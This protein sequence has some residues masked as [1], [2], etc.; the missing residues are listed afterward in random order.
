VSLSG[1]APY[2]RF[3][4]LGP[5]AAWTAT[6]CSKYF[7]GGPSEDAVAMLEYVNGPLTFLSETGALSL[8]APHLKLCAFLTRCNA[9]DAAFCNRDLYL[10]VT[11]K[12]ELAGEGHS[13]A[14]DGL[15]D[16]VYEHRLPYRLGD[17]A[18]RSAVVDLYDMIG[19]LADAEA[20][21]QS[22][23]TPGLIPMYPRYPL[24]LRGLPVRQTITR[25]A[26][27][28]VSSG[29]PG[30]TEATQHMGCVIAAVD[31]GGVHHASAAAASDELAVVTQGGSPGGPLR[32]PP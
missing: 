26:P 30:A 9:V 21:R 15:L 17:T 3:Y 27:V 11:T 14:F 29:G 2:E 4:M 1:L 16:K 24:P 7:I 20:R 10:G 28:C 5:F 19:V 8:H 31:R 6:A 32:N 12:L 22:L 18:P 13:A 25:S 23:R